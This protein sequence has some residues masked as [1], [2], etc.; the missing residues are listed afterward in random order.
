VRKGFRCYVVAGRKSS[1]EPWQ[2][3][4]TFMKHPAN[5]RK[6][7]PEALQA[8]RQNMYAWTRQLP[9]ME[10]VVGETNAMKGSN[11]SLADMRIV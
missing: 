8:A 7:D 3:I 1:N 4:T 10:L 9:N 5:F 2:I 11:K 6:V